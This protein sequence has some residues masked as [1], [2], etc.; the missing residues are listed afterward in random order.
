[1]EQLD[2]LMQRA[3]AAIA[4]I[5]CQLTRQRVFCNALTGRFGKR[6]R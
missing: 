5:R 1:M 3:D 4:E 2:K 6:E